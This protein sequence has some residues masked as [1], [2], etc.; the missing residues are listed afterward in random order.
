MDHEASVEAFDREGR[1]GGSLEAVYLFNAERLSLL[2]PK[3]GTLLDL[4]SGSGRFLIFM[5]RCRP[6]IHIVGVELAPQ[7]RE[8]GRSCIALEGLADRVDLCAGDMTD[9][10]TLNMPRIDVLSAI[11]SLHHLADAAQLSRCARAMGNLRRLH[12]CGVW[13]FDHAR[14]KLERTAHE[15]PAYVSPCAHPAFRASSRDSL[16]A[17]FSF[18]ELRAHLW[19]GFLEAPDSGQARLLRLYQTHTWSPNS[20]RAAK[21]APFLR[22]S[23]TGASRWNAVVLR[24]LFPK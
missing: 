18:E 8:Q 9:L 14:P 11:F 22:P 19:D 7:M 3:G 17:S 12:G 2:L 1:P 4:G 20:N 5:A 16:L 10:G 15:F 24:M 6:D 21:P 13:V 23:L